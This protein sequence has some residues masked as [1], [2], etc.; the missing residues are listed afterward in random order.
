MSAV[1]RKTDEKGNLYIDIN[2]LEAIIPEKELSEVDKFVQGDRIKLYIGTVEEAT[3]YT[4]VIYQE[5]LMN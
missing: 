2:G 4:N 5:K 1:V 3:K